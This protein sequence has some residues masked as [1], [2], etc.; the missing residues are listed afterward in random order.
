MYTL[1]QIHACH[2]KSK[3]QKDKETFHQKTGLKFEE[4]ASK[5]LF[6]DDSFVECRNMDTSESRTEMPGKFLMWSWERMEKI[7][8]HDFV[9]NYKVLHR[10]IVDS[11]ILHALKE[12]RPTD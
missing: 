10:V 3:V 1:N 6:L 8:W 2:G 11:C 9:K 5:M 7:G 12:R 4:E